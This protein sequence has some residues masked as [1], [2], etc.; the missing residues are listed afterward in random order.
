MTGFPAIGRRI[1]RDTNG[2]PTAGNVV[3]IAGMKSG[4]TGNA[5]MGGGDEGILGSLKNRRGDTM[6]I[7]QLPLGARFEY[8]GAEWVKT[9][10]MLASGPGGQRLIPRHAVLKPLDPGVTEP[11]GS[12]SLDRAAVL[13]AFENFCQTCTPWIPEDHAKAFKQARRAFVDAVGQ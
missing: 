10:P 7:H 2:R 13:L 12:P 4:G 6:R 11:S 8:Q 3:P 5:T 1:G 9:A